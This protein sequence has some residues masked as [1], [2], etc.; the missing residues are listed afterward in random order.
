MKASR[1]F[2]VEEVDAIIPELSLIVAEQ[3]LWQSE[4]EE[5][6]AEL[7]RCEGE[8][9]ATVDNDPE[10]SAAVR[11]LKRA[12]RERMAEY[13]RGWE[14]VDVLGGIVKDPQ[15]GRVD[16]YGHLAGRLVWFCW[17]YGEDSLHYYHELHAGVAGRRLLQAEARGLL[18]N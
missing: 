8:L 9:P 11:E 17:R 12:L 16:F 4:I 10:D 18:L 14:R 3:L 1:V 15:I 13:D 6:L 5:C 2:T 7:A